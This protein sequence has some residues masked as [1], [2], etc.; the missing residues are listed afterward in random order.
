M[1]RHLAGAESAELLSARRGKGS[2]Q[3]PS[4]RKHQNVQP[5]RNSKRKQIAVEPKG[6]DS[7]GHKKIFLNLARTAVWKSLS[8][9]SQEYLKAEMDAA[10]LFL[11]RR[12][13]ERE[14]TYKHLNILRERLLRDC[15]N[16]KV[17]SGNPGD[18]KNSRR[19][20]VQEEQRLESNLETLELLQEEI[21]KTVEASERLDEEMKSLQP[22]TQLLQSEDVED[23]IFSLSSTG[24]LALPH[25]CKSSVEAPILQSGMHVREQPGLLKEL[26]T[27]HSSGVATKVRMLLEHAYVK[28]EELGVLDIS[29]Q[30]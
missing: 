20:L 16:L 12:I 19:Y 28:A 24:V 21:D 26:N 9:S 1:G 5:A 7:Q 14:K 3:N 10:M 15:Q 4:R 17:P 29:A 13:P 23:E 11:S 8:C 25:L 27:L 22:K 6:L 18:L 2:Q 30:Q